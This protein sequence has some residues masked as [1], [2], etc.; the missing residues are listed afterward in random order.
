MKVGTHTGRGCAGA[1]LN[2]KRVVSSPLRSIALIISYN[3]D[4]R[5]R[6]CLVYVGFGV[7]L[8]RILFFFFL[9]SCRVWRY[10][11][12]VVSD[13]DST[14]SGESGVPYLL[15]IVPQKDGSRFSISSSYGRLSLIKLVAP[16]PSSVAHRPPRPSPRARVPLSRRLRRRQ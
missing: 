15:L 2:L 11:G 6:V 12:A 14:S 8:Y 7:P 3:F 4:R 10:D 16:F 13:G 9:S 1:R 5:A